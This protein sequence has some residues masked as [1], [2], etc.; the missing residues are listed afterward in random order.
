METVTISPKFQVVIPKNIRESLKLAPGQK[1]TFDITLEI[2]G[3]SAEVAAAEAAVVKI[4]A[5]RPPKI[6]E[7]PQPDWCA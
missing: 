1:H 3:S 5:G 7:Q 4:Q 6:F 2:H